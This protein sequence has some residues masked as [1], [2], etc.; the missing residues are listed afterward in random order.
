MIW[1]DTEKNTAE[2]R[3]RYAL[4]L[5]RKV[6][7]RINVFQMLGRS[8]ELHCVYIC[9]FH[10]VVTFT[11]SNENNRLNFSENAFDLCEWKRGAHTAPIT[12]QS[13]EIEYV[14]QFDYNYI[15][16]LA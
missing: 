2:V 1:K 11:Y 16:E 9:V 10:F 4:L 8:I 5:K 15:N 14:R 13:I 6:K 12:Y 7:Y 3:Q